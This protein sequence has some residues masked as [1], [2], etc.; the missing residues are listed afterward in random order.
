MTVISTKQLESYLWGS[1]KFLRNKIDAGDYKSYIFPLLFYKRISDVY[2][3]E[4]QKVLVESDGDKDFSHS[5]V[6]HQFQIPKNSHWNDLRK[7]TKNVGNVIQKCMRDIEKANPQTLYGIFG[8]V[9]WGNK[10]R[11]SD[12]TLINLIEHF[13]SLNLNIQ[14]IS[15]DMMGAGYEYLIKKFADDSGHTAAEFYTNRTVVSLMTQLLDPRA[16]ESIYDPTCGTGGMLLECVNFL[17]RNKKDPRTLKLFGQ[18]KNLLTSGIT[19][20][21]M[22][23]HGF[24]D[25]Q[26]RRGDIISEPKFLENDKLQTFDVVLANPPYSINRWDR[27]KWSKD[28]FGRNS[29]GVPPQKKADYVFIQHIISS[30]SKNGRAA[31]LLPHG[32]LSS[33]SE[34]EIRKAMIKDDK[35]ECIIGLAK[36]LF[37]NSP[38]RS[39]IMI[40]R[41]KKTS[42]RKNK[43]LFV[44]AENEFERRGNKNFLTDENIKN[45]SNDYQKFKNAEHTHITTSDE[46]LQNDALLNITLYVKTNVDEKIPKISIIL[47]EWKKTDKKITQILP[48]TLEELEISLD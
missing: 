44:N 40:F 36:D 13:S 28:P 31:V 21:N 16:K 7:V 20:I 26:I 47:D 37:Y 5:D 46:I 22:L 24:E 2:D 10:E 29:Y 3:E 32:I 39:C 15:D 25:A 43:V 19:R 4:Y 18:E 9:N 23:L 34:S 45:I 41:T 11:L 30:L 17:K 38:M 6:N 27:K 42:N 35:L 48:T 14:S 1:A 33:D 12:E 8:D